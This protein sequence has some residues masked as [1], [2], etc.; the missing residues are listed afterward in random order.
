MICG[1]DECYANTFIAG[2]LGLFLLWNR[3]TV[4]SVWLNILGI[5]MMLFLAVESW[6]TYHEFCLNEADFF[7][8]FQKT[9]SVSH[10]REDNA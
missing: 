4:I 6:Y 5:I 9:T 7:E 3:L 1:I 8:A 10:T 2:V